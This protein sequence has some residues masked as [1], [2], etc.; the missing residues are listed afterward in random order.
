MTYEIYEKICQE[1]Q[2]KNKNY[3]EVFQN[4]LIKVGLTKKT[5]IKHVDNVDFYIN[6]YLLREEPLEMKEGCRGRINMFL[7]YF[8]IHKCAWSSPGTIKATAA[9]IKKFYK[10]MVDHGFVTK[11]DYEYL[12]DEIK[13]NM[14]SWQSDCERINNYY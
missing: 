1:Q 3:L 6:T 12:T 10:C 2:E 8:F 14:Q 11:T 7:G 13:E 4:D 5:I 9:S